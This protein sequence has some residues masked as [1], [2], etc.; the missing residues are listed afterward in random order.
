MQ[1]T[2][3]PG[4]GPPLHPISRLSFRNALLHALLPLRRS[5]YGWGW[6]ALWW[7]LVVVYGLDNNNRS[8]VPHSIRKRIKG[9][10]CLFLS[11]FYFFSLLTFCSCRYQPERRAH[12]EER[13]V[14][15]LLFPFSGS[16]GCWCKYLVQ[17]C[18]F[19]VYFFSFFI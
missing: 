13:L 9:I 15:L 7:W 8:H 12:R 1:S 2:H 14:V 16:P 17:L 18:P 4:C 10:P 5:L 3:C 11:P 6:Q 19:T